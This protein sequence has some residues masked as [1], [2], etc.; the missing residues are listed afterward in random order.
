M[1]RARARMIRR[2]LY[3]DAPDL[4]LFPMTNPLRIRAA[5]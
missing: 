1:F 5:A 3:R 4:G 2:A